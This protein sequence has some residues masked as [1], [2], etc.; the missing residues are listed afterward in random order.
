VWQI[1]K[2]GGNIDYRFYFQGGN[3][4]W[5]SFDLTGY[6]PS[7]FHLFSIYYDGTTGNYGAWVDTTHV[8]DLNTGTTGDLNFGIAG[9]E[10]LHVRTK[11]KV[12]LM[13]DA[14]IKNDAPTLAKIKIVYDRYS[15]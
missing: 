5:E 4:G 15:E 2:D 13:F 9:T 3:T 10:G 6:D 8:H 1:K 12:C 7:T 11:Q 14:H